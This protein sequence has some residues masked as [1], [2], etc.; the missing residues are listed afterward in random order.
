MGARFFDGGSRF[1]YLVV[2]LDGLKFLSVVEE[3]FLITGEDRCELLTGPVACVVGDKPHD[4]DCDQDT[5][6][7][8]SMPFHDL[9]VFYRLINKKD[10]NRQG[11]EDA[12]SCSA[13]VRV[14]NSRLASDER[15]ANFV[16][17]GKHHIIAP[18]SHV[19]V[20]VFSGGVS[21]LFDIGLFC[22]IKLFF[23]HNF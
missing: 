22:P 2:K 16:I 21:E 19:D 15:I 3:Q 11:R 7:D 5:E 18:S 13:N 8:E 14:A 4:T 6:P 12:E 10:D 9:V 17:L 1:L 20:A 23:C